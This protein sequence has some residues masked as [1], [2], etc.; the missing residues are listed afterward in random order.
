MRNPLPRPFPHPLPLPLSRMHLLPKLTLDIHIGR[1]IATPLRNLKLRLLQD[2]PFGTHAI[3]LQI[4]HALL[5]L[6]E[7]DELL[8]ATLHLASRPLPLAGS[9]PCSAC[10]SDGH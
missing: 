5:A 9:A 6:G 2:P 7:E 1:A 8:L 3:K 10:A 4:V